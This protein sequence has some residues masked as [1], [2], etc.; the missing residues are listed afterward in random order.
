MTKVTGE[1]ECKPMPVNLTDLSRVDCKFN[2][3]VV[4]PVPMFIW[5]STKGGPQN[6]QLKLCI[7]LKQPPQIGGEFPPIRQQAVKLNA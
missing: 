2:L 3:A 4:T 7:G 6:R 5:S 1:A